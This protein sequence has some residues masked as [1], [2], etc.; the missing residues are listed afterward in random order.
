MCHIGSAAA[1]QI[2]KAGSSQDKD[3]PNHQRSS[4]RKHQRIP[5]PGLKYVVDSGLVYLSAIYA[6]EVDNIRSLAAD[7]LQFHHRP[8]QNAENRP[9]EEKDPSQLAL[10]TVEVQSLLEKQTKST[11][12]RLPVCILSNKRQ[13]PPHSR[14]ERTKLLLKSASNPCAYQMHTRFDAKSEQMTGL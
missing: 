8:P 4:H 11:W 3:W 2:A 10:L 6:L 9:T 14:S 12:A 1:D 7:G 13:N 5:L